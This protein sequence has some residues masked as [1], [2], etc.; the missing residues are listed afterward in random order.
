LLTEKHKT[1]YNSYAW[2]VVWNYT[3]RQIENIGVVE[4]GNDAQSVF[5]VSLAGY[6]IIC[7]LGRCPQL[8]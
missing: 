8:F 6:K 3:G 1:Q 4:S 5:S 7:T 2:C